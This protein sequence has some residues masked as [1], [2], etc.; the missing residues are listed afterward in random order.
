MRGFAVRDGRTVVGDC[1]APAERA[2]VVLADCGFRAGRDEFVVCDRAARASAAGSVSEE[3]G[4]SFDSSLTSPPVAEI[5]DSELT[6][7]KVSAETDTRI[8]EQHTVVRFT[9][10]FTPRESSA[11]YI[12]NTKRYESPP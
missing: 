7:L 10:I 12:T 11:G 8:H 6:E 1:T 9:P 3:S 5:S 2:F 4:S